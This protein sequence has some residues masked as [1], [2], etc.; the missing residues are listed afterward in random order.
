MELTVDIVALSDTINPVR[1]FS[2]FFNCGIESPKSRFFTCILTTGAFQRLVTFFHLRHFLTPPNMYFYLTEEIVY[3]KKRKSLVI[4]M[5]KLTF[6]GGVNEVGGNKILLEDRDTKIFLDFGMSFAK[7]RKYY[8]EPFLAPRSE[9]GLL[10]LGI[11]PDIKGIYEF[12]EFAPTIDAVFLTHSHM[13]HSAYVSFID[14]QIPVYCGETTNLILD[15]FSNIRIKNFETDMSGIHFETFRHG[16]KIK[17]KDLE[18]EVCHVDHSTPGSYAF[19]IHTS[20]GSIVYTGD[21]RL[22][23]T[24]PDLTRDFIRRLEEIKPDVFITEA[25]NI[26]GAEISSEREVRYKLNRIV[27]STSKLV[28]A[29]FACADIDRLRT[30]YEVAKTNDRVLAVSLKQAYLLNQ[31]RKDKKLEIPDVTKDKNIVAYRKGKKTLYEWEKVIMNRV[32]VKDS[33]QIKE[34]QDKVILVMSFWDLQELV[35]IKPEKGS[36][37]VLS[38]S[39]PFNE[40]QEIEFEKMMNWL[41]HFGLPE[42]HTHVSGHILPHE[43]RWVINK[44]KPKKIIPIHT[45]RPWMFKKFVEGKVLI[46]RYGKSIE[47]E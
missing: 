24:R 25:T 10:E 41:D 27:K 16:K 9:K 18:V 26:V 17:L 12:D 44:V 8:H 28:L 3:I 32:D 20:S 19:I 43:L 33:S 35:D 15:V 42:Y 14:R 22:T 7:K 2:M 39:E 1:Y 45:E 21:Y 4:I 29:N 23:G 6:Y 36:C 11:L 34:M 37:Y 40:E 13:D 46:P 38:S 5:V 31:L 47:V 30:F